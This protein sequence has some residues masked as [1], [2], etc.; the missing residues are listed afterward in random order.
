MVSL[1]RSLGLAEWRKSHSVAE[2]C[3]RT[4]LIATLQTLRV[5]KELAI[6]W[7][8]PFDTILRVAGTF[9]GDIEAVKE[10]KAD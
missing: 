9:V 2:A 3:R 6:P 8:T 1:R 4:L 10:L 7:F 5:F